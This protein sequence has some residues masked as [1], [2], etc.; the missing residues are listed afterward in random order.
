ME[1]DRVQSRCF[2]GS[3]LLLVCPILHFE[4]RSLIE[5]GGIG[6][7]PTFL[8]ITFQEIVPLTPQMI[9]A[10]DPDQLYVLTFPFTNL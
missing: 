4:G 8:V 5:S 7:E 10:T 9:M 3:F 6:L 1:R 2:L